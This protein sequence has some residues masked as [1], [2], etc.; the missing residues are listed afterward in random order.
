MLVLILDG[1]WILE[2]YGLIFDNEIYC[3]LLII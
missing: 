1:V 3:W 2:I